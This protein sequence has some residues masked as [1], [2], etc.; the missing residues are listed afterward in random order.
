M[1]KPPI[2]AEIHQP[3][4]VHGDFASEIAFHDV[5]AVDGL[6]NLDDL[7][8]GQIAHAPACRD[9][10]FFANIL[11]VGRTDAVDVAQGDLHAL[12]GWNVD[13][14]NARHVGLLIRLA[15]GRA[16]TCAGTA[17]PATRARII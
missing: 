1:A 13:A 14:S 5:V 7:G 6:A 16:S 15:R 10:D 8:L 11:G 4:D 2:A 9:T 12:V 17:H 3:L